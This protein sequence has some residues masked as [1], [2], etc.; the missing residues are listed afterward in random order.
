M[1]QGT[2][3][4]KKEDVMLF[5]ETNEARN[6]RQLV[7]DSCVSGSLAFSCRL[8]HLQALTNHHLKAGSD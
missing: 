3:S 5:G 7:Q 8:V 4:G 2:E 6:E 1:R